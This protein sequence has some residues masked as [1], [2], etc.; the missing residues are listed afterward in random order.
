MSNVFGME[1]G[2]AEEEAAF[3]SDLRPCT[4]VAQ[5][6]VDDPEV[7][8]EARATWTSFADNRAAA[9]LGDD[10]FVELMTGANAGPLW[11]GVCDA[12]G[13]CDIV[14]EG[15][16]CRF[17]SRS[18]LGAE[19]PSRRQLRPHHGVFFGA[20]CRWGSRSGSIVRRLTVQNVGPEEVV[21]RVGQAVVHG[22][23]GPS[24]ARYAHFDRHLPPGWMLR[25]AEHGHSGVHGTGQSPVTAVQ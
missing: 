8:H 14:P 17:R 18:S 9:I 7:W 10:Y 11:I 20:A 1:G 13:V 21:C 25:S 19:R 16:L 6:F 24:L 5:S 22:A 12:R 2:V 23:E 4:F 3:F 15:S